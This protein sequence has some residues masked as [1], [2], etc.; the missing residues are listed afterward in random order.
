MLELI[1]RSSRHEKAKEK[2][3]KHKKANICFLSIYL[4]YFLELPIFIKNFLHF[5]SIKFCEN[6]IFIIS[7][8]FSFAF[9]K[10]LQNHNF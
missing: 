7:G 9:D 6:K 10:N 1:P 5:V 3:K 2:I 4:K 8:V